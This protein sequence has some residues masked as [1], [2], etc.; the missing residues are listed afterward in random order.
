MKNVDTI[1]LFYSEY[2]EYC[3]DVL[4]M[5]KKFNLTYINLI[6]VDNETKLPQVVD[7]V[8][9]II[10]PQN[11]TIVDDDVISYLTKLYNASL[12]S[13]SA[14]VDDQ[15]SA[16]SFIDEDEEKKEVVKRGFNF[17]AETN[18]DYSASNSDIQ[19][20]T[21][22]ETQNKGKIDQREID[23]YTKE[24]ENDYHQMKTMMS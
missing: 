19:S 6:C 21:N 17:I 10:T 18:D 3:I 15:S 12:D 9:L 13:I 5:I 7:R 8:P 22:I 11:K 24:R 2:C 20:V 23:R 16:F 14:L 4:E 1:Y